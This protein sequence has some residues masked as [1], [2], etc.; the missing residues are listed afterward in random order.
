MSVR[1]ELRVVQF[2]RDALL[3][4][5]GDEVLQPFRLVMDF[6]PGISKDLMQERLDQPV[7]PNDLKSALGS[8]LC[9][10]HA[11]M[12]FVDQTAEASWQRASAASSS[13]R[14]G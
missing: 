1:I 6:I 3:E 12:L 5:F 10:S 11:V 7:M 4:S 13:P 2:R 14:P 8:G 9:Q